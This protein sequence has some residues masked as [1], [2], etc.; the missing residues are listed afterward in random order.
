MSSKL[1]LSPDQIHTV[2]HAAKPLRPECVDGYLQTV[3]DTLRA[4]PV[5]GD[6]TVYRAAEAAQKRYF[7]PSSLEGC[8]GVV[9]YGR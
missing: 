2:F 8:V 6:G 7:E 5:I 1:G 9:K 3:A 4:S